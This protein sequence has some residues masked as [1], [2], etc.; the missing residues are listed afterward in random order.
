MSGG[1][2][3][4]GAGRT[5]QRLSKRLA[6][7]GWELLDNQP[8]GYGIMGAV[9]GQRTTSDD[10]TVC[11]EAQARHPQLAPSSSGLHLVS[12]DTMTDCARGCSIVVD[13]QFLAWCYADARTNKKKAGPQ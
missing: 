13:D 9:G 2:S 6:S 10:T 8:E 5:R 12:Y 11:W 1:S 3:S 7:M 4:A